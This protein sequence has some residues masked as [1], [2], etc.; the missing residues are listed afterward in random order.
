MKEE[1]SKSLDSLSRT[2]YRSGVFILFLG[3]LITFVHVV[4]QSYNQSLVGILVFITGYGY[5]K[6]ASKL[7]NVINS[8]K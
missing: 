3:V 7:R 2:C 8:E 4:N 1:N 6:I 5:A